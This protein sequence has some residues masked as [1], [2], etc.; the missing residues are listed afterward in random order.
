MVTVTSTKK[1]KPALITAAGAK[2]FDIVDHD[3]IQINPIWTEETQEAFRQLLSSGTRHVAFTSS[4]AI[5]S[6]QPYLSAA[7]NEY[8]SWKI[9]CLTGRTKESVIALLH[10]NENI[11]AEA[12]NAQTLARMIL[13]QGT[14]NLIFFCGNLRRDE[15]PETLR[16]A[17]VQVHEMVVYE[18]VLLPVVT[19]PADAVL[20]FSPSA[21]ESF[22]SVNQLKPETVCFAIGAT[23]ATA[24]KEKTGNRVVVS[25]V[26]SQEAVIACL[27]T[28]FKNKKH[29]E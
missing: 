22:F 21:V 10:G 6:L 23:T 19:A 24:V 1:L 9:F 3:F 2:G 27:Y 16:A 29:K 26:P 25:D 11:V 5:E 18:T 12:D 7:T 8:K 17:G 4:H 28:Y 14:T 13:E 15:L 20:F